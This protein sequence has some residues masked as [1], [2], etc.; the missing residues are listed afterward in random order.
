MKKRLYL[1]GQWAVLKRLGWEEPVKGLDLQ[2]Y[3]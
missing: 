2:A 1:L 3:V